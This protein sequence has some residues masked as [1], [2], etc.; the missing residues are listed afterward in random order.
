MEAGIFTVSELNRAVKEY[1]EGTRAFKN[2]YIQ[3]EIS[4]ITYYKSGHLY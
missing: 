4:N 2:I 3:G 1:L